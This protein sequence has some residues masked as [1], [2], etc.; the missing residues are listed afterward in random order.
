M[1][2][3]KLPGQSLDVVGEAGSFHAEDIADSRFLKRLEL[4]LSI[5]TA[6]PVQQKHGQG[7]Q[8]F[9]DSVYLRT[10]EYGVRHLPLFKN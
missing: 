9:S 8:R 4:F 2:P 10:A 6:A 1:D 7:A 5:E 3:G